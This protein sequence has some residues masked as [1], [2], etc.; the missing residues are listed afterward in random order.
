M[1][2]SYVEK[3][4]TFKPPVE[5]KTAKSFFGFKKKPVPAGNTKRSEFTPK[6]VVKQIDENT[7]AFLK[8]QLNK[9]IGT[10]A[11]AIFQEDNKFA[12][13]VPIKELKNIIPKIEN[14]TTIVL[15][16]ELDLEILK[17]AEQTTIKYIACTEKTSLTSSKIH[18]MSL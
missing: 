9:I 15:D 8:E 18:I 2:A 16:G 14:P 4:E 12:G 13:R 10:K 1:T 6:P 5:K 11:T 17:T 3:N 7:K